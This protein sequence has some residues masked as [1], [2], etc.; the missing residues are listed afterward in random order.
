MLKMFYPKRMSKSSYNINYEKLYK[1]GYRGIMFDV[2]NTLVEHDADADERAINLLNELEAQGFATLLIS[3]NDQERVERFNKEIG[4][5]YI[6]N[7]HKPM[8]KN[9]LKAIEILGTT[10]DT[11]V[12]VGDQLFTDIYGANRLGMMNYLVKPISPREEIQIVAK[13]QLEKVVLKLYKRSLIK[14]KKGD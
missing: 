6:Y 14:S 12:F 7:A 11:T 5:N 1:E 4:T 9:Y 8:K 3:N 13:R 10:L 2:D